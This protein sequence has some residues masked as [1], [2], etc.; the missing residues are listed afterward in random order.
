MQ[1]DRWEVWNVTNS[2]LKSSNLKLS[3]WP[4]RWGDQS[5]SLQ[6]SI[7]SWGEDNEKGAIAS[8]PAAKKICKDAA[9]AATKRSLELLLPGSPFQLFSMGS[10]PHGYGK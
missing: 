2:S 1:P 9:L 6:E 5:A 10:F 7:A 8:Q 4:W 3:G